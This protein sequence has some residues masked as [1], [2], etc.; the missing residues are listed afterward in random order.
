MNPTVYILVLTFNRWNDTRECLTSVF[1]SDAANARVLVMDNGSTDETLDA[2]PREFPQVHLIKN[3][4]NL[5]YAEGN[6]VGLRFALAQNAE[7]A[8]V[9]NND[10]TV[11]RNWLTLL[12]D[13]AAQE[14]L[15][16]LF[17]PMVY[18]ANES[19][20]IQSAGGVLPRDWHAYHRGANEDDA[21]QFSNMQAVDWLTGCTIMARCA[22]LRQV[23]LLDP[24][25]YMYGEDVDW[26]VRA[27]RA[28][29][30]VLFVPQAHVWHKG[31]Q[32]EYSPSPYVTYY[33]ARNELQLIRKHRGGAL[34]LVRALMRHLRTLTSWTVR[35]RWHAQR[36]HRDALA[37]ALFDFARGTSGQIP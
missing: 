26:C 15:G 34:T 9:L 11:A 29:Y 4:T 28:G 24:A 2:L 5:G 35:P 13:A 21:G 18:H 23:G 8:V 12:L 25:F 10:V 37:H 33:S 6:N 3:P 19:R 20:V 16:A 30:R 31:V 32:R 14:P 27:T 36:T 7:F 1:A 17:G 22:R